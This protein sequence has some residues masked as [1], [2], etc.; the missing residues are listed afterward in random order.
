M[1]DYDTH[2]ASIAKYVEVLAEIEASISTRNNEYMEVAF[3]LAT[4]YIEAMLYIVKPMFYVMNY[5]KKRFEP[6]RYPHCD[7]IAERCS[8]LRRNKFDDLWHPYTNLSMLCD[9]AKYYMNG[10]REY[11]LKGARQYIQKIKYECNRLIK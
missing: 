7:N 11:R 4:E 6:K 8:V 10:E 2:M 3:N 9:T 1:S 5:E